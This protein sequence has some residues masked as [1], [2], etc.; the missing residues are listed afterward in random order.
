V[1]LL[2]AVIAFEKVFLKNA[3]IAGGQLVQHVLL[4]YFAVDYFLMRHSLIQ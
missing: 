2:K 3:T 1:R 4:N